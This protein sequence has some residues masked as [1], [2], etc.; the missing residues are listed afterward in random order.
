MI[1]WN[2]DSRNILMAKNIRLTPK[3]HRLH[4]RTGGIGIKEFVNNSHKSSASSSSSEKK[5]EKKMKQMMTI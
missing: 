4:P 2:D 3:L 5:N 1:A